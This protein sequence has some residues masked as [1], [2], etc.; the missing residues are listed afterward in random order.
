MF[1]ST[2]HRLKALLA[3]CAGAL[4]LIAAFAGGAQATEYHSDVWDITTNQGHAC[5]HGLNG[6][7]QGTVSFTERNI[8]TE[9]S[10]GC[11]YTA[12]TLYANLYLYSDY[13]TEVDAD[14]WHLGYGTS[15]YNGTSSA[16]GDYTHVE[17]WN[18]E[19]NIPTRFQVAAWTTYQLPTSGTEDF[20]S[21]PTSSAYDCSAYWRLHNGL[22]GWHLSGLT[23]NGQGIFTTGVKNVT[24]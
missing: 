19:L 4:A 16:V 12:P 24:E 18:R 17:A 21:W 10:V 5:A 2:S 6:V 8:Y 13:G 9:T 23:C 3:G 15:H 7:P 1:E 20:T 14:G 11:N 22:N